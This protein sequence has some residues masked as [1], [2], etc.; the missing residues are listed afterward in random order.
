[1][2]NDELKG[3]IVLSRINVSVRNIRPDSFSLFFNPL[4][5]CF[6]YDVSMYLILLSRL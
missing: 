3:F 2:T 4:Y 5:L 6:Q 1:M